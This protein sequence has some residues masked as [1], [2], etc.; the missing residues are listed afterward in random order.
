MRPARA[1]V[2]DCKTSETGERS[3]ITNCGAGRNDVPSGERQW[4]SGD[5]V[6]IRR[7]AEEVP[8]VTELARQADVISVDEAIDHVERR[9]IW[10]V[11]MD[12]PP[13][14]Q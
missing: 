6:E 10:M 5:G 2:A 8:A 9:T 11:T 12:S 1:R 13:S 3:G 7:I 14:L 4:R